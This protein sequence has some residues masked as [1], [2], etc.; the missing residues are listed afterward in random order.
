MFNVLI[1]A[2][3]D[4]ESMF[5]L[6]TLMKLLEQQQ[7]VWILC[8]TTGNYDGLGH[9]RRKELEQVVAKILKMPVNRLIILDDE[10]NFPDHP[11]RRWPIPIVSKAIEQAI[12][13]AI[14]SRP[15]VPLRLFS[16]DADGVS[17][18]RNHCDTF[19]AVQHYAERQRLLHREVEAWGL[20]T[21]RNPARKYFP[22]W[23]WLACLRLVRVRPEDGCFHMQ[24][25]FTVNWQA[26]ALH[27]SQFVWY[28]RLFVVFSCYTYCNRHK[29]I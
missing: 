17:G 20:V 29:P 18:H 26:M 14:S 28:R 10:H 7:E 12:A 2:H 24:H 11:T 25:P 16:F 23:E 3:P 9:L 15:K 8:L 19:A 13:C 27:Q 22:I 6:P 1:I 5:F 21:I 4:D